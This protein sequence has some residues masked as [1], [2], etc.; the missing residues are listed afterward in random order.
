MQAQLVHERLADIAIDL[1]AAA[2]VLSRL[3]SQ[4]TRNGKPTTDPHADPMFGKA[5]LKYA[6]RRVKNNFDALDD[7]DDTTVLTAAAVTMAK[8]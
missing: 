5:F 2:C 3:D 1:Y 7:N 6:Y 4:L 8:W